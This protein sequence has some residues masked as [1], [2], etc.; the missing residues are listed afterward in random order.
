MLNEAA[1]RSRSAADVGGEFMGGILAEYD[2]TTTSKIELARC[3][4]DI[5]VMALRLIMIMADKARL[6]GTFMATRFRV[7]DYTDKLQLSGKSA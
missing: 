7:A 5:G 4:T 6:D 1:S 2:N 3:N